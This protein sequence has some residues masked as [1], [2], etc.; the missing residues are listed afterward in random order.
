M[1]YLWLEMKWLRLFEPGHQ[2]D[3]LHL[4]CSLYLVLQSVHTCVG[5]PFI[6]LC[7]RAG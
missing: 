6:K 5:Q 2:L 4:C 7:S 1:T 3:L